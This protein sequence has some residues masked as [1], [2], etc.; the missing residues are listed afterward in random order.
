MNSQFLLKI[1]LKISPRRRAPRSTR[2]LPQS[3][4][5]NV[6]VADFIN[7]NNIHIEVF[8]HEQLSNVIGDIKK[9]VAICQN[10]KNASV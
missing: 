8:R 4:G 9:L 5:D 3:L 7:H 10:E 2:S 6:V 1:L